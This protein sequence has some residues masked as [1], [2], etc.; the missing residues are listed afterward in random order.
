MVK[1]DNNS[2][3]SSQQKAIIFGSW[4]G[5]ALDGYDLVLML[6]VISSI[7]HLFFLS[8]DPFLNLLATFATYIITLIVRPVGGII[9]GHFGDKYGRKK[10][11]IITIM[12]FSIVTFMTGLLPTW[13]TVG[14]AA[15]VL[16]VILRFIQGLFA[17][18]E[19]ASGSVITMETVPKK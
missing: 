19:W 8:S 14:T 5:W 12:G 10:P 2:K 11:L 7:N 6:F 13:Q 4:F 17:G 3:L 15:P 16:L 1:D 18:G 9:F